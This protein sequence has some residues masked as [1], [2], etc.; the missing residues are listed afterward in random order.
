MSFAVFIIGEGTLAAATR[1]CCSRHFLCDSPIISDEDVLWI[2]HD[3]PLGANDEPDTEWVMNQIRDQVRLLGSMMPLILISSQ[4]PVG[5]TARLEGEYPQHTFAHSP[6]NIRVASGVA[7]FENQARIVVGIRCSTWNNTLA[8]LFSP[9]T[10]NI[11][12]TDPESAEMVKHAINCYLGMSIAF[13]NEVARI[14]SVV[15]ADIA[16]VSEGLRTDAR[17]SPRAPLRPGAPF[18]GGHLA[19]DIFTM[20][21]IARE[22]RISLPI[23]EH[24]AE[25]NGGAKNGWKS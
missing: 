10:K 1:E 3:T 23:I 5:T 9:F 18:G 13:A 22:K 12:F 15:G 17:V 20:T 4:L 6:E 24:I 16:K 25:S 8:E 21:R 11:I 14:C 19:R 7:D 2:C